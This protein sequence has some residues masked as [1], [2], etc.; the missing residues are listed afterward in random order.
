ML[1][2]AGKVTSATCT[3]YYYVRVFSNHSE[4]FMCLKPYYG[5]MEQNMVK[6]APKRISCILCGHSIFYRLTDRNTQTSGMFWILGKKLFPCICIRT[7]TRNTFCPPCLHHNPSI[8]FLV[9]TYPHHVDLT[10]KT[11][12]ITGKGKGAS[13]LTCSCFCCK[14]FYAKR[15][16]IISLCNGGI[17]FVTAGRAYPLVLKIY[18]RRCSEKLL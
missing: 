1:G 15:L 16:I 10:F 12:L 11:K 6:N 18:P 7:W 14:S 17:R 5:L 8:G 3:P 2:T 9:V 4:L 13:P